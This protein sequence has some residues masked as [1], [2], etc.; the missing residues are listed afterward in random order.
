MFRSETFT[1]D[2]SSEGGGKEAAKAAMEWDK[3]L[4]IYA[5]N[6]PKGKP[7]KVVLNNV[8]FKLIL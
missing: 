1:P 8:K 4:K 3:E 5:E 7:Y 6:K 2:P